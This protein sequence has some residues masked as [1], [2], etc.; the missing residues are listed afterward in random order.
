M[1][2]QEVIEKLCE[3]CDHVADKKFGW[4]LSADCFCGKKKIAD[5]HFKFDEEILNFIS[6]AVEE[7]ILR[8]QKLFSMED[9][10]GLI[11]CYIYPI[12]VKSQT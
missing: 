11:S 12:S 1:K 5:E 4:E 9:I 3:L 2:K 6:E 10:E 7:K 8:N